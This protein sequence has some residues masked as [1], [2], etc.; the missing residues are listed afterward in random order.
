MD[1]S[2]DQEK[3]IRK[4]FSFF[5][6]KNFWDYDEYFFNHEKEII[7][8]LHVKTPEEALLALEDLF[9]PTKE[10]FLKQKEIDF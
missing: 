1:L 9:I 10:N 6:K 4:L 7:K 8:S 5:V 3:H 2:K